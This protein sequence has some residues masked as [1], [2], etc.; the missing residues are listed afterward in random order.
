MSRASF[1]HTLCTDGSNPCVH[2]CTNIFAGAYAD[3]FLN[4]NDRRFRARV[5]GGRAREGRAQGKE[6]T[7]DGG[8]AKREGERGDEGQGVRSYDV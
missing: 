5:L 4:A 7:T 6:E 2:L 3:Q 1:A 8:K